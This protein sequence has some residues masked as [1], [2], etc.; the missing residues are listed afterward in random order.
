MENLNRIPLNGLRAVAAVAREGSL[1]AAAALLNVTP[2]AVSQQLTRTEASL[3]L[4]LFDRLPEGLR[5]TPRGAEICRM[6]DQ[7]FAALSTAV[8]RA[9]EDRETV[10]TISVAP[11]FA[12]RWLIWRLPDFQR[13]HPEIRVR[14]DNQLSLVDPN[15]SDVD[16]CIR[17]GRGD[18][19]GT[20][21]EHL[22]TQYIVPVCSAALAERIH[23]PKDLAHVP[24]IAE[25]HPQFGWEAWLGPEGL[26]PDILQ[27]PTYYPD[28]SLC[29]DA[30]MVGAGVFLA[31]ETLLGDAAH[32]GNIAIPIPRMHL[33]GLSYWL[34]SAR[35][36]SL[37]EPQRA[38]RRW[39]KAALADSGLGRGTR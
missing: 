19:P 37:S 18:Y 21:T 34:I 30:A 28:A 25:P 27:A 39:L 9:Q 12:A 11:I 13:D 31:F 7:G 3:G 8:A 35:D 15:S 24:I 36:R 2:G 10:L 26:S 14:L 32:R 29:F 38:F 16:F 33:S 6:L 17:I 1:S 23:E 20:T 5:P 4:R 22:L